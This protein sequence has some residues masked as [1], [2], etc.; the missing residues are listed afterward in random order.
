VIDLPESMTKSLARRLA[1]AVLEHPM[2]ANVPTNPVLKWLARYRGCAGQVI[3]REELIRILLELAANEGAGAPNVRDA[4]LRNAL[5][6]VL[7]M[8]GVPLPAQ[9]LADI[10]AQAQILERDQPSLAAHVRQAKAII[11]AAQSDFVGKINNWFDQTM[12]RV[13]QRY[14]GEARAI[15]V[16]SALITAFV[17]QIDSID[18]IRRLSVDDAF[19]NSLLA[20]AKAQQER[21]DTLAQTSPPPA[22]IDDL[23]DAKAKR[24]EIDATLAKLR[25]PGLAVLPDHFIWQRVP[26]AR[27]ERNPFWTSPW[28]A[29]YELFT[30]GSSISIVPTW[31]NDPIADLR[32]A[33]S[34]PDVPL[35][36]EYEPGET[37]VIVESNGRQTVALEADVTIPPD[38]PTGI[39]TH[40]RVNLLE[41]LVTLARATLTWRPSLSR[42]RDLAFIVGDRAP[43][44]VTVKAGG[45]EGAKPQD[46]VAALSARARGDD[47]SHDPLP[48]TVTP[49]DET[50]AVVTATT[51]SIREIRLLEN[52]DDP[53]SNVL[54]T[55]ERVARA[56]RASSERLRSWSARNLALVVAG[57]ASPIPDDAWRT[58]GRSSPSLDESKLAAAI[59]RSNAAGITARAHRADAL[60]LIAKRLGSIELRYQSGHAETNI[61]DAATDASWSRTL[62][63]F[64][65]QPSFMG[66]VLSWALLSLGA[67]FWYDALKNLLKLRPAPAANEEAHRRDRATENSERKR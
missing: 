2:V 63:G 13:T 46:L 39:A 43:V 38:R 32:A 23:A 61:L 33:L 1:T 60:V 65:V 5:A 67:P 24:N 35:M 45:A 44:M 40:E 12:A 29:H 26:Q 9:A 8:N 58:G 50:T 52:K 47:D 64:V 3:E 10:R 53:F 27:L 4:A 41:P 55:G 48:I 15:T 56:W 18:L 28:P 16:V 42:A 20:E 14:A 37:D 57:R 25:S 6:N 19:R 51:P 62:L 21:I 66:V 36:I 59:A 54:T 34:T 22:A 31:R 7:Q 11:S 17:V 49:I 30:G